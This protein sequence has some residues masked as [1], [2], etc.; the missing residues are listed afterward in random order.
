MDTYVFD[1]DGV[2]VDSEKYHWLAYDAGVSFEEYCRINHSL[3]GP[4]FRET[5]D[6]AKKD[7]VYK[8]YI[9]D[10]P[11]KE[12][13]ENFY[14]RLTELGKKVYIVTNSSQEIFDIFARKFPFLKDISVI[15]G[16]NKPDPSGYRAVPQEGR[17]I[18][19]EDSYRGFYAA[20][21]VFS[22]VVLVNTHDYVY[23]DTIDPE[24]SIENFRG[25][26]M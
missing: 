15:T 26:E 18:V 10:I 1:F 23:F 4:Y 25:L 20:S 22:V 19:F 2:V 5:M 6:A 3:T 11:L 24:I 9:K 14:R 13:F 7:A 21:Q 16:C 17:T 12:G 8:A